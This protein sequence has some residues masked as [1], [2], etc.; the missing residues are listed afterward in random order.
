MKFSWE[1][2]NKPKQKN[3]IREEFNI[4]DLF[5]KVKPHINLQLGSGIDTLFETLLDNPEVNYKR[6]QRVMD[7]C[8]DWHSENT[9]LDLSEFMS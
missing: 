6:R 7:M 3:I 8:R 4:E 2:L 5:G 1:E 9:T